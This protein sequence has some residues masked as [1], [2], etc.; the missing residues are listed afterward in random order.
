MNSAENPHLYK[1]KSYDTEAEATGWYGPEVAFGLAYQFVEAGE[2]MLDL[3]IGTGLG[4]ALFRK[5]GIDVH[6]MDLH[7]EMLDACRQ[8]GLC[9][10]KQHDL[11]EM[12]YPYLQGSMD[13]ALSTG[14][15]N[16]FSNLEPIITEVNRILKPEGL[17][18]FATGDRTEE[19]PHAITIGRE[20][21]G[22]DATVTMYL[23]TLKQIGDWLKNTGFKLKR[24]LLFTMY[25]D[26]DKQ[27]SRQVRVYLAEKQKGK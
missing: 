4:S 17:F 1:I 6:G 10:L 2:T 14:V 20:H 23:H 24:D 9:K 26:S 5:A 25:M 18:I 27:H 13:H 7:R 21:T 3:G 16:F 8:K 22:S 19:Q 12:P 11:T 15:L